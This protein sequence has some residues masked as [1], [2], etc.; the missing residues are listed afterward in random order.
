MR[1]PATTRSLGARLGRLEEAAGKGRRCAFCRLELRSQPPGWAG[2]TQDDTD[3][4]DEVTARCHYCG[5][6]YRLSLDEVPGD[7]RDA[8]RLY[9]SY[10]FEDFY[11]DPRAHA[12]QLWVY[13][14][15]WVYL[16]RVPE[17]PRWREKTPGVL[18]HWRLE[19]EAKR[20]AARK[21]GAMES[22][23]GVPFPEHRR[24]LEEVEADRRGETH[25][26]HRIKGLGELAP[27]ETRL[28]GDAALERIVWGRVRRQTNADLR[29]V[30]R[31]IEEL[32]AA[33]DD[34]LDERA[35]LEEERKRLAEE[36]EGRKRLADEAAREGPGG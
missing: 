13:R 3:E 31:L 26:G 22:R 30:V 24:L 20:L 34:V 25:R 10:D 14:R 33:A 29:E 36:E 9:L 23:H 18:L 17:V 6:T 19:A 15:K 27:L 12:L 28:R 32:L 7:E 16:F 35:R 11:T 2:A 5:A 8:L 21:R 4:S 1:A